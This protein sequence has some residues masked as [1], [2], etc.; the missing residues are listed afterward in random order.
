[1]TGAWA[2]ASTGASTMLAH[3]S[4]H[5]RGNLGAGASSRGWGFGT[6][7]FLRVYTSPASHRRGVPGSSEHILSLTGVFLCR[8]VH[9]CRCKSR[10]WCTESLHRR[11]VVCRGWG[12]YRC[13]GIGAG[14]VRG[15]SSV[16]IIRTRTWGH[17]TSNSVVSISRYSTGRLLSGSFQISK[18]TGNWIEVVSLSV[19]RLRGLLRRAPVRRSNVKHIISDVELEIRPWVHRLWTP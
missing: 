7:N 1:M 17:W 10:L 3:A 2:G 13:I 15:G 19:A 8:L 11:F 18:G 5:T 4:I 14:I 6:G 12:S 9:L 16:A